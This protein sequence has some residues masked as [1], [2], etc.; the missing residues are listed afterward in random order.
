MHP[1]LHPR[2][3][4]GRAGFGSGE[5]VKA[6][7]AKHAHYMLPIPPG[8]LLP[9]FTASQPPPLPPSS[10]PSPP[11]SPPPPP[12]SPHTGTAL[13]TVSDEQSSADGDRSVA[14]DLL[15]VLSAALYGLY[16]VLM[17]RQLPEDEH[18]RVA[19]FF[20]YVGL[21]TSLLLAPFVG[22][23]LLGGWQS[24]AGVPRAIFLIILLEGLLDYVLSDYLWAHSVLLLGPTLATLGLSTQIPLAAVA[25]LFLGQP[26][27]VQHVGTVT[28]TLLGT[29]L[30][31]AGFFKV[32]S[33]GGG[34]GDSG[35]GGGGDGGPKKVTPNSSSSGDA[36]VDLSGAVGSLSDHQHH[37]GSHHSAGRV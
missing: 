2:C 6:L 28:L 30:I 15:C 34:D 24:L 16:T 22:V 32:N 9:S 7:L 37:H 23:L 14:G 35:G 3:A 33:S 25:D 17:R 29:A 19:L 26:T 8:L 13:I 10:P 4:G 18:A 11:P 1:S 12:P 5:A 36:L 27:W 20:G 31:L 21:F